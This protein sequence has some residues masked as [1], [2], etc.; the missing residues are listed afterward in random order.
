MYMCITSSI[1]EGNLSCV[2]M[3]AF[4]VELNLAEEDQVTIDT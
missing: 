2:W 4:K 1:A 3:D